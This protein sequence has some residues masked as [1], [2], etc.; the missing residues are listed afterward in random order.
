MQTRSERYH[1]IR[2]LGS[3][4]YGSVHEALDTKT[5]TRVA[6]KRGLADDG[7]GR[8]GSDDP[9]PQVANLPNVPSLLVACM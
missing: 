3:G 7:T 6:V 9:D 2:H 8:D 5:N 1:V 4:S